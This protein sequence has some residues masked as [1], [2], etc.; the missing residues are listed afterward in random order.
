MNI[1]KKYYIPKINHLKVDHSY[2]CDQLNL[3]TYVDV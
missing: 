3:R 2:E 1:V